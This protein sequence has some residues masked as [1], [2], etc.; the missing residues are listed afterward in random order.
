[1][2]THPIQTIATNLKRERTRAKLSISELANRAQV[3]K[4]TLSQLESGQANPSIETL[5]ALCVALD[6][7]F[8][9]LVD[10][11][12]QNKAQVIRFGEGI[13]ME[14]EYADY[15]A[16]LLSACPA[17]KARDLYL[18]TAQP[19]SQRLSKPHNEGTLEHLIVARGRALIGPAENPVILNT[20]DY[21]S[22]RGDEPHLF[23]ALT[24][25]TIAVML[26]EK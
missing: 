5:W 25:D 22:Y 13:K 17:G 14:A 24:D 20:G 4:S 21:I 1:M 6:I 11:P 16:I 12:E 18:V 23:E 19:G 7:T 3:G 15:Q 26:I 9:Q 2:Q 8:S 10:Q